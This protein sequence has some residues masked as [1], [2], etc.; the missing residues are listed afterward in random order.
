LK[1]SWKALSGMVH[2]CFATGEWPARQ[3]SD[4]LSTLVSVV[5]LIIKKNLKVKN[6]ENM[7]HA[8]VQ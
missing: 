5:E 1:Q 2:S 6:L 7:A 8:T 3:H 4:G